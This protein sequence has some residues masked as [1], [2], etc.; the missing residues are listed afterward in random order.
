MGNCLNMD[1]KKRKNKDN[2]YQL[3]KEEE[4]V[5]D[6]TTFDKKVIV[7]KF[8][9]FFQSV[10][11]YLQNSHVIE[12]EEEEHVKV[13]NTMTEDDMNNIDGTMLLD[14]DVNLN[15]DERFEENK[16]PIIET[17]PLP[18]YKSP[19]TTSD[20]PSPKL[21][22]F[23]DRPICP[24]PTP[25][26]RND[27]TPGRRIENLCDHKGRIRKDEPFQMYLQRKRRASA[28]FV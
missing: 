14:D 21:Y 18:S 13:S 19:L 5:N 7:Q 17:S 16:T 23:D 3:S 8:N 12:E 10:T 20:G 25:L 6:N 28:L 9:F 27:I 2:S 24:M 26:R 1:I 15:D 11:I 22:S 4:V